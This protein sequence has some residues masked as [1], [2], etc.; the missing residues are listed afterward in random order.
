MV[1]KVMVLTETEYNGK[2]ILFPNE[3]D[4]ETN[5]ICIMST[6]SRTIGV[7]G[8]V[9]RLTERSFKD[10]KKDLAKTKGLDRITML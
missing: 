8:K 2:T 3:M 9:L 4:I 10:V 7:D 5:D 1:K 6:G